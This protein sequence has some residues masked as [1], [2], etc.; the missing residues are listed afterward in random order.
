MPLKVLILTGLDLAR[1]YPDMTAS[2]GLVWGLEERGIEWTAARPSTHRPRPER[3]DAVLS[4]WGKS[5]RKGYRFIPSHVHHLYP[6]NPIPSRGRFED[7]VAR[8]CR[9]HGVPLIN[10]LPARLELRHSHCL[11]TW[12]QHGI[13]CA[14]FRKFSSFEEL[15][16]SDLPYP[17]ILRV[18]GGS[19]SLRDA[20]LV[21]SPDEARAA[22]AQRLAQKEDEPGLHPFTLA[23]EFRENR[24]SDGYYRKRRSFLVGDRMLP[25]QHMLSPT[26]Q[27]K[28]QTVVTGEPARSENRRFRERGDE[29]AELV[30][31][32][33][34]LLGPDILALDYSRLEDGSYL[35]WEGNAIFGM[36]GLGEE[37][38]SR[39]YR[40]ATGLDKTDCEAEHRALGLAIADLIERRVAE[41][42]A[43]A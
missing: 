20:V 9:E 27:V 25:R 10:P 33:A 4:W 24:W 26:W 38:K 28:L 14:R 16:E 41:A 12:T 13:P 19:H 11:R 34:R 2:L 39:I 18:D 8:S 29:D 7:D 36:A 37:G 5:S 21:A 35:F 31:R 15:A 23:I 1:F 22:L 30:L 40:E 32:A 17:L 6:Y 43:S 3:Y 42:R